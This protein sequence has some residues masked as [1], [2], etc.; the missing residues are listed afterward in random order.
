M[1]GNVAQR[2]GVPGHGPDIGDG[3]KGLGVVLLDDLDDLVQV[4]A[5]DHAENDMHRPQ[6]SLGFGGGDAV[7]LLVQQLDQRGSVRLGDDLDDDHP[8]GKFSFYR[9]ADVVA[10][11]EA[12]GIGDVVNEVGQVAHHLPDGQQPDEH[13]EEAHQGGEL[14][15]APGNENDAQ[16]AEGDVDD[17]RR[18][19]QQR[20]QDVWVQDGI[21]IYVHG[22]NQS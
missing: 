3:E 20:D 6:G 15:E 11:G 12:G 2:I 18:A 17:P 19:D 5:F 13:F 4:G 7:S 22:H 14:E 16:G 10:Q 8:Q 21:E 9:H 1:P